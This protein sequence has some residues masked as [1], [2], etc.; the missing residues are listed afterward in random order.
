MQRFEKFDV[1]ACPGV[2]QEKLL[3]VG[4]ERPVA[5]SGRDKLEGAEEAKMQQSHVNFQFF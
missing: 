1:R 5:R 4:V 2:G 3:G